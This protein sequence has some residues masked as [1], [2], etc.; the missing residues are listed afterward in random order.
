MDYTALLKKELLPA[1]GCT[2]PIAVA[3]AAAKAREVLGRV[4][5]RIEAMCSGCIIKNVHSVVVPH[6]CDLRGVEAAAVLGALAG[7]AEKRLEVLCDVTPDDVSRARE[8]LKAGICTCDLAEG[9][10]NLY[11]S[12]TLMAGFDKA[13]VIIAGEHTNIIRIVRNGNVVLEG[14]EKQGAHTD[15]EKLS[16]QG[17]LSYAD[18]ADLTQLTELLDSEINYNT[19][20]SQRGLSGEYG[21]GVGRA[22]LETGANSV[23]TRAIAAAAAGSDARMNGCPLAVVINSGSGNQGMTVSL[24]VVEYAQAYRVD[25][26]KLY[27]ALIVAN[28]IAI[29]QKKH[30]GNLSA[31]CGAVCAATGAG[32]GV[33]YLLGYGYREI[34]DIISFTLGTIS[35]MM[36]DGA[37]S[38]CAA[39]IAAALDVALLGLHIATTTRRRFNEGEGLIKHSADATIE[40]VGRVGRNGMRETNTEILRIMLEKPN[41][42][43][44]NI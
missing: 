14:E 42:H 20:I 22:V 36:C 31:Y 4:P 23:R 12:M 7:R 28:L 41:N 10:D 37:K 34:S 15:E 40:S 21:V 26:E 30:I 18:T 11:I 8:A 29:E 35:G 38:S 39:K 27:R 33:A 5:E 9:V 32:C 2:E 19:A 13:T 25:R 43:E 1:F 16:V 24:P 44:M 17:I 3:Y 6:S